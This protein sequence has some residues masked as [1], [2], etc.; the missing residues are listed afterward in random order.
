V[1]DLV[2]LRFPD[3]VDAT[4]RKLHGRAYRDAP[5]CSLVFANSAFTA[6]DVVERLGVA[7][8]RV[9]VAHPG[10]DRRFVPGGRRADRGRPYVLAVGAGDPRKN[11]AVVTRAI[12]LLQPSR[13]ELELVAVGA[14]PEATVGYVDDEELA[15]LYRGASALAYPSRFEGFG[16]PVI[17]AMA[18]GT[19][20]VASSHES[21]DAAA[22]AAA[23]RADPDS[24]A[25]WADSLEHAL[26]RPH[27]LVQRGLEHSRG[28][29]WKACGEAVLQ[30]YLTTV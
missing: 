11:L 14:G 24:A 17:E 23:L 8:D 27:E 20:V 9:L 16:M 6:R 13:P 5:R 19:P 4:T 7:E 1:H 2:P 12:H 3:W 29:T 15:A 21:L 18:C 22:G 30:G 26:A 25:E 28:F 10:V